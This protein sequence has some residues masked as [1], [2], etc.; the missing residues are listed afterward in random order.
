MNDYYEWRTSMNSALA[1]GMIAAVAAGN[2]GD[3]FS[4][5]I[6]PVPNNVATPGRV[7]PP[8]LH[9]DQTRTGGLSDVITAGA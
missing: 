1:A 8:W 3:W 7:P 4:Q 6:W 5:W 2:A 9:P